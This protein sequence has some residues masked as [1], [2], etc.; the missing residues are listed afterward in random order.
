MG[1]EGCFNPETHHNRPVLVIPVRAVFETV[2]TYADT[3]E[4][5]TITGGEPLD[6]PMGL[7]KLLRTI[8]R[9]S[10]LSVIVFSGYTL[11]RIEQNPF[12]GDILGNIDALVAG[13]YVHSA[14]AAEG[15]RGSANQIVHLLTDRYSHEELQECPSAEIF[16]DEHGEA[17]ITGV[18]PP[19]LSL[20]KGSDP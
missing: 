20:L 3:I 12:A 19:D 7:A 6:Q 13:P 17:Q 2:M 4:G 8:K 10:K 11:D 14:S 16:I 1:C 18:D 5:I 15:L 9:N